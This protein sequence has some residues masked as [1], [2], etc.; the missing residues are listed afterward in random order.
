[1]WRQKNS[2]VRGL[3]P[4]SLKSGG[5]GHEPPLPPV[6]D[7]TGTVLDVAQLKWH[8]TL[9]I[10][11]ACLLYFLVQIKP[12]AYSYWVKLKGW[13]FKLANEQKRSWFWHFSTCGRATA[14]LCYTPHSFWSNCDH[15]MHA[16]I[17]HVAIYNLPYQLRYQRKSKKFIYSCW[18]FILYCSPLSNGCL[19]SIC[20]WLL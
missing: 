15:L 20:I 4:S 14:C 3:C 2:K 6:S 19:C 5:G 10:V 18:S 13:N 9:H 12:H 7:A 8:K 1:M 11:M 17:M 16:G